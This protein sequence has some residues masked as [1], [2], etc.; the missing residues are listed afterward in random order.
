MWQRNRHAA[1]SMAN[2][3]NKTSAGEAEAETLKPYSSVPL[4]GFGGEAEQLWEDASS[5]VGILL[6]HSLS[7]R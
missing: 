6:E 7:G 3:D 4:L 5:S 2:K 1:F